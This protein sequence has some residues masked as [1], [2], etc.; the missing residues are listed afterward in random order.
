MADADHDQKRLGWSERARSAVTSLTR[1]QILQAAAGIA[2][3][4]FGL[5][6]AGG[7]DW[8]VVAARQSMHG[9]MALYARYT[10]RASMVHVGF[11]QIAEN[12]P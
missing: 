7:A 11:I 10:P 3:V 4:T 9:R 1:A 2:V 12:T 8:A 5:A 6:A